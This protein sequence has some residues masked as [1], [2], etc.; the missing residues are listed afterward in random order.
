M[1]LYAL[2]PASA[3]GVPVVPVGLL[4]TADVLPT[5]GARV[6]RRAAVTVRLGAPLHEPTPQ[7]ARQ[8]VAALAARPTGIPASGRRRRAARLATS[9]YGILLAA[10][11]A[12]AE[13]LSWPLLPE[14]AVGVLVQA[15]PRTWHRLPPA[16]VL[17]SVATAVP[18][19]RRLGLVLTDRGA[20]STA[21]AEPVSPSSCCASA[22]LGSVA[23][24][25]VY[26]A[27]S[28]SSCCSSGTSSPVA[29]QRDTFVTRWRSA[30]G[31]GEDSRGVPRS[32]GRLRCRAPIQHGTSR[33][34]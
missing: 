34:C 16:A 4:G 23:G 8:D 7:Q 15:A 17:D 31:Q 32:G 5:G 22:L 2:K 10:A 24:R 27:V 14:I 13:M 3:A 6:R 30:P 28:P 26:G 18:V 25:A 19:P 1:S 29:T 33:G 20:G 9:P 12:F 11:W 21:C